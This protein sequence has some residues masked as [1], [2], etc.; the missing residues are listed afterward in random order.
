MLLDKINIR[1]LEVKT[2]P[3]DENGGRIISQAGE[4]AQ[5]VSG[6]SFKF[7]AYIE[8]EESGETPRGNHYHVNKEEFFYVVK[9]RLRAIYEN[10][11][12]KERAETVL[13]TGDL[14][15]VKPKCAHVYFPVEYTQLIEFSTGAFDP[16][17]TYKH[18]VAES[19]ESLT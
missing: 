7:L 2:P 4:I 18:V 14:V 16:A 12:T 13:E 6:T 11:E 10:L 3:L 19:S 5:I 15:S 17:D 9:G 8:F 1:R